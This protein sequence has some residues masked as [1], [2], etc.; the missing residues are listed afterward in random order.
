LQSQDVH[1]PSIRVARVTEPILRKSAY[2]ININGTTH[3]KIAFI[4]PSIQVVAVSRPPTIRQQRKIPE[5][6]ES[7]AV[8]VGLYRSAV[9]LE[10][11]HVQFTAGDSIAIEC[12]QN[13]NILAAK[14]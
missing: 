2:V 4:A 12:D 14:T 11:I 10:V 6:Y 7:V 5:I 9:E 13:L 1:L 3:I 8:E